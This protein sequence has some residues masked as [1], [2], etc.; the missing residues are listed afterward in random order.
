MADSNTAAYRAYPDT[1]PACIR[2]L[3]GARR[4]PRAPMPRTRRLRLALCAS[5]L[6]SR[7]RGRR[8]RSGRRRGPRLL[9]G[10]TIRRGPAPHFAAFAA[11]DD[12]LAI[13]IR[14]NVAIATQERL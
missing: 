11:I 6:A 9:I 14:Q 13:D 5:R 1:C 12:A 3:A 7:R 2:A 8:G 10:T 4:T